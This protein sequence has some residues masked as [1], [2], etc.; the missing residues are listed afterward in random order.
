MGKADARKKSSSTPKNA[1][2]PDGPSEIIK[3]QTW[4]EKVAALPALPGVYIFKDSSGRVLYV[5]KAKSLRTRARSYTKE[6]G[7]GRYHVRFLQTKIAD[8]DFI[9]TD[10]EKEALILENNLIKKYRP[11]YNIDLRD[12]KTYYH[13]RLTLSEPRPRL[14]LTRRP[15]KGGVDML[16][17]PFSS[18]GAVKETIRTLQEIFPLR[19]CQSRFRLRERPCLNFQIGKCI[20]PCAEKVGEEEYKQVVDQVIRFLKGR[21]PELVSDL[22]KQMKEAS[23]AQE[24]ELAA[25]LR[26]RVQAIDKTLEQQKVDSVHPVD[27]DVIGFYR[28]GDR[29]VIHRL[30]YR[31]GVLLMSDTHG[32]TKVSLPD[33]EVLSS[34][35]AQFYP[36]RGEP[37]EEILAPFMPA[38][39]E[40]LKASFSEARGRHCTIR[41]PV[42][43]EWK[44]LVELAAK[45]AQETWKRESERGEDR[46]RAMAQLHKRLRLG[47]LPG[48]IECVDISILGGENAVG[49]MVKFI[50]GEPDKSGYRRYRIREVE[51]TNDYGMMQ[52]VLTRRFKRAL[53]EGRPLPDLLVVDGGK[54]QLNV[55][56][57]VLSELA[58]EGLEVIALAKD[59]EI[60]EP[61][62]KDLR[63]KGER[64]FVPGAK[65]PVTIKP[66]TAGLHLLQRV[67][68]EAHR[69]AI[70]YHKNLRG[71]KLKRSAL[72]DVP[73]IGKK[74]AKALLKHFKGIAKIRNAAPREI[75][76]VPGITNN[77]ADR[78]KSFLGK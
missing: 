22:K 72:E 25:T 53:N 52:E 74:K 2:R 60:G 23:K 8:L 6:G 40:L 49:S 73:G 61:L 63:K 15:K 19:R 12:D 47:R 48:W 20:G 38:D 34:F 27:R 65:D 50:E 71:K 39:H 4:K 33:D 77:D 10:T 30:G 51:G 18:S 69:F 70:S 44:K 55:A 32:F 64:V 57:A 54:G 62:S 14:V 45:N 16:F 17:G 29:V 37:P 31:A 24:F 9:V 68:D 58:I 26:D 78:I 1:D 42:R 3:K 46:A 56:L 41:V 43:G 67:R 36:E 75:A 11:R 5:G 76:S 13:I 59:K 35:L 7:D 28:E 21:R 66:G